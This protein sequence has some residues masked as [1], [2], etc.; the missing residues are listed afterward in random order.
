LIHPAA[1]WVF[2]FSAL[3]LPGLN[4][5]AADA[6]PYGFATFVA[7]GAALF[8]VRWLDGARWMDAAAF[9]FFG[10]ALWRVHLIDWPFYAVLFGYACLR[11]VRGESAAGWKWNLAVFGILAAALVPVAL[12]A[13]Q[14][15]GE[16]KSHVIFSQPATW[17][18]FGGAFK[19]LLVVGAGAGACLLGLF[20]KWPR[21]QAPAASSLFLVAGWWMCQPLALFVF[22]RFTG[23]NVFVPRYLSLS[24]PGAALAATAAAAYFLP[25]YAWRGASLAMAA[26]VVVFIGGV[27]KPA[28]DGSR[29]PSAGHSARH[30][31]FVSQSFH[32]SAD[33][34]LA[35][36]LSA[37]RLPLLPPAPLSR[38]RNAL[39]VALCFFPGGRI[40]RR[41][42]L[43][44]QP[45]RA[46]QIRN[47]WR[48]CERGIL[49]AFLCRPAPI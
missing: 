24:L 44:G 28:P 42:N 40:V 38:R 33:A 49:A 12:T 8:L 29:N 45:G 34:P 16:A 25:A 20:W 36:G 10:A 43:V 11:S 21:Q 41:A 30:S 32:R 22:S 5:E 39:L 19:F 46:R 4:Y 14:L 23:Q 17:R 47:L 6:R 18:Q 1:A 3:T 27:P 2:A 13:L 9:I 37:S 48:R 35:A 26:I 31:N 15:L 7:A